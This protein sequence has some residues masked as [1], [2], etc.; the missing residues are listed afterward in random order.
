MSGEV[1]ANLI[2]QNLGPYRIVEQIGRGGMATVYKAYEPALDRYVAIKVL[3]PY[4]A[5]DPSFAARFDREAKAVA[6]LDHPNI[7]PIYNFGQENGL[8]YI[9][10]RF[11][12]EGTLKDRMGAPLDLETALDILRQIAQALDYA[13][14]QGV[15]HRDIK[16]SNVL[17]AEG[18]T[19][20]SRG[21]HWVLLTDFGLARMVGSSSQ[22]TKS[23]VGVGT[24]AYMSP[25]QGQGTQVDARSDLYSLGVVLYE[26]MTGSVPYEAE[27]PM[28]VVLKHITAPLPMPRSLN[29]V[30]P[31]AAERVILKAMAKNP[32]DRFQSAQDMVDALD[33]ALQEMPSMEDSAG[34]DWLTEEVPPIEP[35]PPTEVAEPAETS[36]A[37]AISVEAPATAPTAVQETEVTPPAAPVVE[38]TAIEA[39]ATEAL[40]KR[41]PDK[42]PFWKRL[43]IWAWGTI[44]LVVIAAVVGG[45]LLAI[46]DDEWE[47]EG[48]DP[49]ATNTPAAV[50]QNTPTLRS[51]TPTPEPVAPG[52]S[53]RWVLVEFCDSG[54]S[55]QLCLHDPASGDVVQ[56]T[57]DLDAEEPGVA[58]WSPDGQQIVFNAGK[59]YRREDGGLDHDLYV[60]H[61]D[62]SGLY[63]LTEG[64]D[65]DLDPS[66]SPNGEWIAFHRNCG[67]WVIRPDG[68]EAHEV[69]AGT[70]ELCAG[71]TA[72]SPDSERIAFAEWQA[73]DDIHQIWMVGS[74][75]SDPHVVYEVQQEMDHMMPVW[76]PDDRLVSVYGGEDWDAGMWIDPE[77][78]DPRPAPMEELPCEWFNHCRAW[79]EELQT[80][81]PGLS[82][83]PGD[84]VYFVPCEGADPWQ[85]CYIDE[86]SGKVTQVTHDL[87]FGEQGFVSWSP[88]GTQIVFNAGTELGADGHYDHHIYVLNADGSGLRQITEGEANDFDPAWSPD[89]EWIAFSRDCALWLVRPDGSE[90]HEVHGGTDEY[91][92]G[93][94]AWSPDSQQIAFV[95]WYTPDDIQEVRVIGRDGS[96]PHLATSFE[97]GVDWRFVVWDRDGSRLAC[98]YGSEN[99]SE[100]VAF[101]LDG[102]HPEFI[103]EGHLPWHWLHDH[104]PQWYEGELL[105]GPDRWL[106]LESCEGLDPW[107]ICIRDQESGEV[108]QVTHDLEFGEPGRTTWSPDG[109]QIVFN[110]AEYSNHDLYLINADGTDLYQITRGNN[111][112]VD[113]SWSPDGEWIA[114]HR[115]CALW[116]VRPD[117]SD[118]HEAYGGTDDLCVGSTVWSPNSQWI[119]FVDW[120]TPDDI[121]EIWI[122]GKDGSDPY[123]VYSFEQEVDWQHVAWDPNGSRLACIYGGEGWAEGISFDLGGGDRQSIPEDHWP[124]HWLPSHWPQWYEGELLFGSGT[125]V[126]ASW[127]LI[128]IPPGGAIGIGLV[129]D[130]SGPISDWGPLFEDTVRLA[131][132][133]W[134]EIAG[135]PVDLVAED[136]GCDDE[137]SVAAAQAMTSDPSIAG[138]IGPICTS[139]CYA[140]LPIYQESNCVIVSPSCTGSELS[141]QG[142]SVF[143][144]VVVRDEEG[145]DE[146]NQEIVATG[147]YQD[148]AAHFEERF[149]VALEEDSGALVAHA[150]DAAEI[151]LSAITNVAEVDDSGALV[152]ERQA[153]AG[154]VRG[155]A[156]FQGV[157]GSIHIDEQGDRLP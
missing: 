81:K 138:V 27:T 80:D 144:R 101:D 26:M 28:A 89:G 127:E 149:G 102:S 95:D 100:G 66:W 134:G 60:I 114:F 150:Y 109:S 65:N 50:V 68:S 151:L 78:G 132:E 7:L 137:L 133:D 82:A 5:H 37:E 54:E 62:G 39:P 93:G 8:S 148:F 122:V 157:T 128:V 84:W 99:W 19:Q 33:R 104:W 111:N 71:G 74:D 85:I 47:W 112:D 113:P 91:C 52:G 108:T 146:R 130:Y 69:L 119:A 120:D 140:A 129:A 145:P 22:L 126:E 155:T 152:I 29:P 61:A 23:G 139:A 64:M 116:L 32:V 13:H 110:A 105:S 131:I 86:V 106:S 11:V 56:L 136:G 141:A 9:V 124:W 21:G 79:S 45:V 118:A 3:P 31:D 115:D 70:D 20:T 73:R 51:P 42:V 92:V 41:E 125:T 48:D 36:T 4:F 34:L 156:G 107:Q 142:F 53:E 40:P 18:H 72:W 38:P 57:H 58:A 96:D 17:I 49:F 25:E 12:G 67:L 153:L 154:A 103:P 15:I 63:P 121:Q 1:N 77:G 135:F 88:D 2:G 75:G 43:P 83:G 10:M 117:G 97:Q 94:V 35:V 44:A 46:G 24:P 87:D 143:N 16:P 147:A 14:C 59:G 6:R 76:S 30:L 90:A 98:L 55:W 123:L